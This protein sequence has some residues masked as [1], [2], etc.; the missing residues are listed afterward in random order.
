MKI[1]INQHDDHQYSVM[2]RVLDG[3]LAVDSVEEFDEILKIYPDDPLLQRKYADL[4]MDKSMLDEAQVAF[5]KASLLFIDQGPNAFGELAPYRLQM[6]EFFLRWHAILIE[7]STLQLVAD[8]CDRRDAKNAAVAFQRVQLT[9]VHGPVGSVAVEQS[10]HETLSLVEE[11]DE[12]VSIVG[13]PLEDVDELA[14]PLL[15]GQDL[16]ADRLC[17]LVPC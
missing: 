6:V 2:Q 11:L 5:K 7:E 16:P 3:T 17:P 12:A 4:L 15:L 1:S 14:L 9:E 8:F 10:G 13:N